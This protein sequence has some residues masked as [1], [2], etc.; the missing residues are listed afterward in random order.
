[1]ILSVERYNVGVKTNQLSQISGLG[2]AEP[3]VESL[4]EKFSHHFSNERL[5]TFNFLRQN[6]NQTESK[7]LDWLLSIN[8]ADFKVK[9]PFYGIE[10][11]SDGAHFVAQTYQRANRDNKLYK[12]TQY[13]P[14]HI[15]ASYR[16]MAQEFERKH[17]AQR[18][19][20]ASAYRS[21]AYQAMLIFY[22]TKNWD[23]NLKKVLKRVALP[24]YSEHGLI[25][26]TAL[27]LDDAL[28]HPESYEDE[29]FAKTDHFRWLALHAGKFGFKLSYP[30][31][32]LQGI[33]Y[34]PWHW[35]YHGN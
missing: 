6:L 30:P 20:I 29:L 17:P 1:M 23:F 34:E 25:G 9:T 8:P 21:P 4:N 27:D 24:G 15:F 3:T 14:G 19:Y 31:N 10:E 11:P 16:T 5:L 18:L 26:Q 13:V 2:S 7:M 12:V 22:Y 28:Q 33:D 35:R 32:N